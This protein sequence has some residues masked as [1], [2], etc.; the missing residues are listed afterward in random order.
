QQA[1]IDAQG[2]QCGFCTAGQI[3]TAASLS[4]A[5]KQELP[6]ARKGHLRRC[7]GYRAIEDAVHGVKHIEEPKSGAA[8]GCSVPAPA[9]EAIVTGKA[10]YTLD[11]KIDGMLHMKLLRSP[12]AHARIRSIK[13]DAALAVPG[14]Q[15]VFT[16]EDVPR[17]LYAS[18]CHDDYHSDPNDNY[19]LDTV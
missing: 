13:R 8:F 16:W 3:M 10:A 14:V 11:V 12:H 15:A 19:I 4:D 7:T 5:D 2:F 17:R 18:A 9:S 6:Q 1:F